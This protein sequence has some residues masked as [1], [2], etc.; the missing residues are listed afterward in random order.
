MCTQTCVT[1]C[2]WYWCHNV[3]ENKLKNDP[4]SLVSYRNHSYRSAYNS[5]TPPPC[6]IPREQILSSLTAWDQVLESHKKRVRLVFIYFNLPIFLGGGD[7]K[8]SELSKDSQD[9]TLNLF[10]NTILLYYR[11]TVMG[12]PTFPRCPGNEPGPQR[13]VNKVQPPEPWYGDTA[14]Y[15]R[16]PW[17]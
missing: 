14:F 13:W 15:V 9:L 4:K 1:V 7:I 16:L 5:A 17:H 10:V 6:L 12:I 2:H 8:Y 3:Y 11:R